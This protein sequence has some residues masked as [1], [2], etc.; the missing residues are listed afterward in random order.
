M[1]IIFI[2]KVTV[3]IVTC[4]LGMEEGRTRWPSPRR[5][6]FC[7]YSLPFFFPCAPGSD[8]VFGIR[9]E[10]MHCSHDEYGNTVPTILLQLQ[11]RLYELGG[12]KV[13]RGR[14]RAVAVRKGRV[15][16]TERE[17]G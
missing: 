3:W 1:P 12:L 9:P 14:R 6:D 15:Y 16:L 5:P 8:S 4:D 7:C 17:E 10:C 11:R 2:D 13:R